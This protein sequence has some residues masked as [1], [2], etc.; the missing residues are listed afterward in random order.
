D[1]VDNDGDWRPDLDDVGLD[2]ADLTGDFGE[3]DGLPT[4]G[5][6]TD[7]PGEPNLD[8]TDVSESDQIG[9]RNVQ[10][11][12]AAGINYQTVSDFALFDAF[13]VPG[14]FDLLAPGAPPPST[15]NDL[16]VSS[17]I[18]PLRAGQTERV[19]F[20]V[21]LGTVDYSR[22]E[23]DVPNRYRDLLT[24]R[25][26]AQEAYEADYRFAQA[27]VCPT[28]RAVPGNGQ[29]TLY[30]DARAEDSFDSFIADLD[31]PG[32]N[33]RD[34][35][36]YR[37]Y[38][39]TDP[40]FLDARLVTDGFGNLTFLRPIA[41]FDLIDQYEGFHPVAVNGT[42]F[43]LG[44]NLLDAGEASNG[45][46]HVFTDSTAVNGIS[47]YYAVTSYDFGATPANIP[48]TECAIAI[49]LN[50]D[51]SI[52][53]LGPNVVSVTPT[54]E[55]AGYVDPSLT[56]EHRQGFATGTLS[57]RVVDPT[58]L[59]DG[60]L[61]RVTFRDTLIL[62][63]VNQQ[64]VQI[65]QDTI[66]T[67]DFSLF[68]VTDGETLLA[69]S[70]SFLPQYDPLVTEGF[71]LLFNPVFLAEPDP[72]LSDWVD[73]NNA[74]FD[75]AVSRFNLPSNFPGTRF[76]ADYRI[77][78]GGAGFGQSTA[79]TLRIP[80]TRTLQAK[81]TN[82]RLF[83][84][85][86]GPD[87]QATEVEA[88]YAFWDL[89]GEGA[90]PYGPGSAATNLLSAD[91]EA[92][93]GQGESDRILILEDIPGDRVTGLTPT[94]MVSLNYAGVTGRRNPQAGDDGQVVIRKPFLASDIFEF[95][96]TGARFDPAAA[97]GL[98]DQIRVVPNPYVG[99]SRFE[100]ANPFPSGRGERVIR[101]INLPPRATIRIFTI[102]GRLVR[103]IERNEGSNE[104]L[105]PE[106]LLDGDEEWD[107][108]SE[109]NLEV[110]YGVYLYHVEAPGVG[111]TTGTFA[112]IK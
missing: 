56:I 78:V 41:Q 61:Y 15:D 25:Q 68:D 6:G 48:P 45:L 108:L 75:L 58:T 42:Q 49:S 70:L 76:P 95:S 89:T 29:V 83:R 111:E 106:M 86:I 80:L 110:S 74:V 19:S 67:R 16:F 62:G 98:L 21:I 20:A 11:R 84:R 60:H 37:V 50:P 55:A 105:T 27:P 39:A 107:L 100:Q 97:A 112:L 87:G 69:N 81:P 47:Y 52:R 88:Q 103:T 33:P 46:A 104:G 4:S 73:D 32:L 91:P 72:T 109:D 71:Q 23:G 51:G 2:G 101:F 44:T 63:Q 8:V 10:Y 22:N 102:S 53:R 79:F 30:W 57:Y 12:A 9:I 92:L 7:F 1:G 17:G 90:D 54:Q 77:E 38:R 18:F 64:G 96:V 65:T 82:F 93:N 66:R 24:K 34:F 13:L 35:E 14:R 36:G 31:L 94:W 28:V 43:Y 26:N 40:A 99:Q 59:Q 85:V 3:N 5:A